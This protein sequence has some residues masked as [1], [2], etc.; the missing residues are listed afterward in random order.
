MEG[1]YS[2]SLA[3]IGFYLIEVCCLGYFLYRFFVW[4]LA[5]AKPGRK[6][7]AVSDD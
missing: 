6:E 1:L 7:A 2:S 5:E 4:E 3:H